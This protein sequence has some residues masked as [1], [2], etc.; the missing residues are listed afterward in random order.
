MD[1][2]DIQNK[3]NTALNNTSFSN[4]VSYLDKLVELLSANDRK[5]SYLHATN[6]Y[7]LVLNEYNEICN[8]CTNVNRCSISEDLEK[9]NITITDNVDRKHEFIITVH[10]KNTSDIFLIEHHDLPD[11]QG[12]SELV[13]NYNSLRKLCEKFISA[14]ESLQEFFD[15][16]DEVD[17][18]FWILDPEKPKRKDVYRRIVLC[19]NVSIIVTFDPYKVRSVPNIKFLGPE[20]LI[21]KYRVSLMENLADFDVDGN[22]IDELLKLLGE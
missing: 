3:I 19:D 18:K 5:K 6:N 17:S 13:K 4:I 21:E 22:I 11:T 15:L 16:M 20:R 10:L 8:F 9:I 12:I 7:R 14:V 1:E 2:K